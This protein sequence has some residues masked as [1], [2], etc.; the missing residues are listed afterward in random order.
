[1]LAGPVGHH[2]VNEC[3]AVSQGSSNAWIDPLKS[4]SSRSLRRIPSAAS[5]VILDRHTFS[6]FKITSGI[7]SIGGL[8]GEQGT[9]AVLRE[10][11]EEGFLGS[12]KGRIE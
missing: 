1:M 7:G 9:H 11:Q 3:S 5:I 8:S 10:D 2:Q 6:C 12:S 4:H